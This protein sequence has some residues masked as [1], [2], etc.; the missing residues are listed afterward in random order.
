MGLMAAT[1]YGLM[2]QVVA[3]NT[4]VQTIVDDDKR[5]RVMAF[6]TIAL[7]GSAPLGSLLGGS[8]A[9]RSASRP[10]SGRRG[11]LLTALW[12]WRQ[13]PAIRESVRPR[14]RR[15]R[16][17]RPLSDGRDRSG[18]RQIQPA[19]VDGG[20]LQVI[21]SCR[22]PARACHADGTAAAARAAAFGRV[23]TF[24]HRSISAR[25]CALGQD[26]VDQAHELGFEIGV[27][28][29]PLQAADDVLDEL[30]RACGRPSA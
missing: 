30:A 29:R 23:S 12:F 17:H 15:A 11:C 10:R 13:L 25:A 6:Y 4:I 1:G 24:Q 3:T 7:L 9:A 21:A 28:H 14:L 27:A 16:H 8:L 20:N 18:Q 22:P 26:A 19:A 2:Y 5:G